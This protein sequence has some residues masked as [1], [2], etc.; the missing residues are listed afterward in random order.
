MKDIYIKKKYVLII[1]I[2]LMSLNWILVP[3]PV[4]NKHIAVV[5]SE[6]ILFICF[7]WVYRRKNK[8]GKV[9]KRYVG[10]IIYF[11][12]IYLFLVIYHMILSGFNIQYFMHIRYIIAGALAYLFFSKIELTTKARYNV[13][14]LVVSII[15]I[16]RL[17]R[18]LSGEVVRTSPFM[19][20]IIIYATFLL[21]CYP[22]FLFYLIHKYESKNK[23]ISVMTYLNIIFT[24]VIMPFTGSRTCNAVLICINLAVFLFF[25]WKYRKAV[26][27][28]VFLMALSYAIFVLC[29]LFSSN[30]QS[31]SYALRSFGLDSTES[32]VSDIRKMSTEDLEQLPNDIHFFESQSG[33][34]EVII[35]ASD[36]VRS[37]YWNVAIKE[38]KKNILL[39]RGSCEIEY[40]GT[41]QSPHNFMLELL[42]SFGLIGALYAVIIIFFPLYGVISMRESW[43]SILALLISFA[44][45]SISFFQPTL[46]TISLV[47]AYYFC[48]SMLQTKKVRYTI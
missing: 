25:L 39:G 44:F 37:F 32:A 45:F 18:I 31:K 41:F 35:R 17:F 27:R 48:L 16:L 22:V 12:I 3:I 1:S 4:L 38:I 34:D 15:N 28:C 40:E 43:R 42:L 9:D 7:M 24:I 36:Q 26:K 5:P 2:F 21:I 33:K 10:S 46:M 19:I 13:L 14:V 8:M 30:S 29:F 20:N 6:I 11:V 23:Y 47:I